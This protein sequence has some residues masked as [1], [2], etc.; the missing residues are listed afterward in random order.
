[1]SLTDRRGECIYSACPHFRRCFIERAIRATKT[2]RIVIANHALVMLLATGDKSEESNLGRLIFDEGHHVFESA[3]ATF[4]SALT[5][6]EACE[7]RRWLTGSG[8]RRR[9]KGLSE[10]TGYDENIASAVE[11]LK[12]AAS[13]LPSDNWLKNLSEDRP[14][15]A[16][17]K[18]LLAIRNMVRAR[19]NK[20]AQGYSL[21]SEIIDVDEAVAEAGGE[22]QIA[23]H[24]LLDPIKQ[25]GKR[26]EILLMESPDWLNSALRGKIEGLMN[27]LKR[28]EMMLSNWLVL[29]GRLTGKSEVDFID[30][31]AIDRIDGREYDIGIHR[32][33]IDPTYPLAQEVFK[34]SHGLLVTSATLGVSRQTSPDDDAE[35]SEAVLSWEA[36]EKRSGAKHLGIPLLHFEAKSPFDYSH[37][38]EVFIVNDIPKNNLAA[39]SNGYVRL[40]EAAKGGALGLFSSIQRLRR[41]YAMI[42]D[43]LAR[44]GLP[45]YAQHVDPMDTGTLVDIFRD[46]PHAS[47]LGTDALRD[48]IDVPGQSLRL[49][50]MEGLPWPR[51]TVAH[52]ARRRAWGG[53]AYDDQ[54]IRAKLAQGFGRLI[55]SQDDKGAFVLL[56]SAVP[57]RLLDAFPKG[58]KIN[59]LS[60]EETTAMIAERCQLQ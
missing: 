10:I 15:N 55:R 22:S 3:D 24:S 13:L 50:I 19:A 20:P 5:G 41:V 14:L 33:W 31:L 26:L 16:I 32:H 11:E 35:N 7:L 36:A 42:V 56:S 21:E 52:A 47:L 2:A 45:L 29:I 43:H 54:I 48:G 23:I 12:E 57:S 27:G 18:L 28:R 6:R 58:V 8:N 9:R 38:A 51:P 25:I 49:V 59:R 53:W 1:M 17:E 44:Q 46:D 39:L 60:L 37:A 34:P 40:L 30:W 4:A